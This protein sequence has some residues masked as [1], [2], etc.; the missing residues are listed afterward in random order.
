MACCGAAVL[1]HPT[2]IP[3]QPV[4]VVLYLSTVIYFFHC[5]QVNRKVERI[6]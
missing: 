4:M 5:R 1:H 6:A 2:R 3:L